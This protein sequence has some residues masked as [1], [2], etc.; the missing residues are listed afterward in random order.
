VIHGGREPADEQLIQAAIDVFGPILIEY[1]VPG[2]PLLGTVVTSEE[3]LEFDH[4]I[5]RAITPDSGVVIV[6][7]D[8]S[9]LGADR[10]GALVFRRRA[11]GEVGP[12]TGED[13]H[14]EQV[15]G[16]GRR[17]WLDR[18]GYVHLAESAVV[19]AAP[20]AASAPSPSTA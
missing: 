18:E 13:L 12:A 19:T 3:W 15:V 17:A 10:E 9:V 7:D 4:T 11:E 1:Y 5:G 2:D 8:G 14:G 6:G 16:T 20:P